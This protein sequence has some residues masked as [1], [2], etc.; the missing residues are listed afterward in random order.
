MVGD[1]L[2]TILPRRDLGA[3]RG[4]L[5]AMLGDLK[6]KRA[7][8]HLLGQLDDEHVLEFVLQSLGRIAP[9]D[10]VELLRRHL[11]YPDA[12][13]QMAAAEALRRAGDTSGIRVLL[14][15]A[16]TDDEDLQREVTAALK[17]F[18]SHPREAAEALAVIVEQLESH[19]VQDP[20]A[21]DVQYALG[22]IT[23]NRVLLTAAGWRAWIREQFP[24]DT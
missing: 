5:I 16:R 23:G 14:E 24:A 22:E 12:L 11:T 3:D 7:V 4:P 1:I 20:I 10:H 15:L 13:V 17:R 8:P 2:D 9:G 19:D 21:R 18:K 6:I